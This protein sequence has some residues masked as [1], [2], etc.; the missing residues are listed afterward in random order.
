MASDKESIHKEVPHIDPFI[1]Q[2]QF[3]L[4]LLNKDHTQVVED[5]YMDYNSTAY[6]CPFHHKD[7][8]VIIHSLEFESVYSINQHHSQVLFY[9]DYKEA[10]YMALEEDKG[11]KK[12]ADTHFFLFIYHQI[13]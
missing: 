3:A 1:Y 4:E 2:S 7:I 5:T 12:K 6:F 10:S 11:S 13:F 8:S 9:Q